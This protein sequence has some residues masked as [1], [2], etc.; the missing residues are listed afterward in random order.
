MQTA[1]PGLA[2]LVRATSVF[3]SSLAHILCTMHSGW[4]RVLC[5]RLCLPNAY[6]RLYAP[7]DHGVIVYLLRAILWHYVE[8]VEKVL[9]NPFKTAAE[10]LTARLNMVLGQRVGDNGQVLK[11]VHETLINLS[12]TT[13]SAFDQLGGDVRASPKLHTSIRATDIRHLLLLLP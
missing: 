8:S 13:L 6:A 9:Q 11:G 5:G 3:A 10:K 12:K 1:S 2:R 7:I 4:F